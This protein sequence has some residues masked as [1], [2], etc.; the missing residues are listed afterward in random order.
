MLVRTGYLN[1]SYITANITANILMTQSYL[2]PAVV[3]LVNCCHNVRADCTKTI[4][5][6]ML[7]QIAGGCALHLPER[8]K[9]EQFEEDW[10]QIG[11][12]GKPGKEKG[13]GQQH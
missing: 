11:A 1:I 2:G 3:D 8:W 6:S 10:G 4:L 5:Q 7:V 9:Q 13:G 12:K